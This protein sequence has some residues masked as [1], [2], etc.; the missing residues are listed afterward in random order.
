NEFQ[1]AGFDE[2]TSQSVRDSILVDGSQ[3]RLSNQIEAAIGLASPVS[4]L[5]RVADVPVYRSDALVRRAEPLQQTSASRQPTARM[6][7]TTLQQLGVQ[8]GDS[9]RVRSAQ[10]EVVLQAELDTAVAEGA[11]RVSTAFAETLPLG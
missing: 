8:E 6:S 5:Q 11:V 3:E 1:L 2:E 10:G 7:A 4:G 9:V